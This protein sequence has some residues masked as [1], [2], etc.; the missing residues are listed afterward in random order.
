[1]GA[2][3]LAGRLAAAGAGP[4]VIVGLCLPRGVELVTAMV[5]VWRA[6]AAY[7][8]LDPA[9]PA[10]RA[11]YMLADSGAGLVVSHRGLAG[12]LAQPVLWLEELPAGPAATVAVD[13]VAVAGAAAPDPVVAGGQLAYVIYTSGST[14][15][16]KGV[17]VSHGALAG[18]VGWA[19]AAYGAGPGQAAAWHTSLAFDL[20]LTSVLVPLAAGGT[21]LAGAGDG[22]EALAGVLRRGYRDALVKVV[23]A[24]L[25]VLAGQVP[26]GQLARARWRL[27]VGGEALGG[28]QVRAWL[29]DAPGTVVVN[30][31]GPTEA[32]VGCCV[33]RTV[34]GEPVPDLVPIGVPAANTRLYVLDGWLTPVP[35]GVAGELYIGGAQLARGYARRPGLTG[36]RFVACPFGPG[37]QR[38]YRTGDLA[39]WTADGELVYLGRA[40]DQVKIRGF[41]VEPGEVETVLAGC[42]GWPGPWWPPARTPPA[43]PGWSPTWSRPRMVIR[44]PRSWRRRCGST[45]RR[46]CRSTWCPPRWWCWTRCR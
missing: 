23:P 8:P 25:A 16:P 46:G 15:R 31:Y 26:G 37:G 10:G 35:A 34:A 14:G 18:Y 42:P 39:R 5:A 28:A 11:G 41:R 9:W 45:R 22:P 7:L 6:G 19:A 20:A 44:W 36:E 3:G 2:G 21:V 1:M 38:M 32:V 33:S 29:R 43:I 30:E 40:D 12:G 4:E 24:H 13:D 17:Q 27:V